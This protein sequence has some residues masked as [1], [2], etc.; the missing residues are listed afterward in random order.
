MIAAARVGGMT[1]DEL[2]ARAER[3]AGATSSASIISACSWSACARR[4]STS[5]SRCATLRRA[6]FPRGTFAELPMPL[7][8]NTVDLERGAPRDLGVCPAS[9]TSTCTTPCT[10]RARCPASS[11][12]AASANALCIDG[13]VVDNLPVAIAALFADLD[14]R[15][16]RR[17]HRPPSDH[18]RDGARLREHL[19]ARGDDDDARAPAI[20]AHA[21]ERPADGAHPSARAATDW[22]SFSNIAATIRGRAPRRAQGARGHRRVLRSAR[23][24]LSAP[25]RSRSRSTGTSASAAALCVSLAPSLMGMD[26]AGKAYTRTRTVDW[27]PADGDFVPYCPTSAIVARKIERIV[28][29]KAGERGAA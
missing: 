6:S 15:G 9:R 29:L 27:S 14:H 20:P 17:Q 5:R 10:R 8:V 21:L 16:R 22:L 2:A 28:P 1:P 25:A 7:L 18:R 12:R 4:R 13:G 11:R 19:H 23:R 24:R 3:C 26:A